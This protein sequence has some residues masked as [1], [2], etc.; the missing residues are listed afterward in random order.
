M[1]P[2]SVE[3]RMV[4]VMRDCPA[5]AVPSGTP[6][7]LPK[8]AFVTITQ[9]RGGNYTVSF[10]G[11]LARVDGTDAD[12]LGLEVEE[13]D[14]G[15]VEPGAP[16]SEHVWETLCTIY[17]PE[18]PVNIVD[19]GLIYDV[20]ISEKSAG[21]DLVTVTMTLTS[22]TCGMGQVLANDVRYRLNKVPNVDEV[23][24]K[25]VFDPPWS[26]DKISEEAQLELGIF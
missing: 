12:A 6:I 26:R 14:F 23:D 8:N 1:L 17:D 15:Q 13:L 19:L 4:P 22:P 24:V 10:K 11:N 25:L 21:H 9:A 20:D 5:R 7:T 16:L 18:I 2:S 3:Q